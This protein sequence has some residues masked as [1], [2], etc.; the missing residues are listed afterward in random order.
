MVKYLD[1]TINDLVQYTALLHLLKPETRGSYVY[2]I[3]QPNLGDLSVV[4]N[5]KTPG[6]DDLQTVVLALDYIL[7]EVPKLDVS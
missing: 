2:G 5:L 6:C 4:F 3:E 7:E 1:V